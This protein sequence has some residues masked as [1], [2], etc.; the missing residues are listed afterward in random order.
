ME[1]APDLNG[2]SFEVNSKI[3]GD[4]QPSRMPTPIIFRFTEIDLSISM[5]FKMISDI[6]IYPLL[7]QN[8]EI[9]HFVSRSFASFCHEFS[10]ELVFEFI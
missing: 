9:S 1:M 7:R 2:D 6:V 10:T 8:T 4:G 5:S 3:A